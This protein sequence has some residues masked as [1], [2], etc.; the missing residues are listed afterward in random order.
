[1]LLLLLPLR[2]RVPLQAINQQAPVVVVV[3]NLLQVILRLVV[4]AVAEE[5]LRVI[6]RQVAVVAVVG[7]PNF[8]FPKHQSIKYPY[9]LGVRWPGNALLR[10]NL[11]IWHAITKRCRAT[12]LQGGTGIELEVRQ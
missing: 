1:V 7:D 4:V 9:L 2:F 10:R 6:S 3:V 5:L 11:H 12:A 8:K